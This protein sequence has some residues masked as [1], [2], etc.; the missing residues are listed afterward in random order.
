MKL[1]IASDHAGFRHKERLID[2]LRNS[3]YE[4]EDLGPHEYN[5]DDDYPDYIIPVARGVSE[6]PKDT[7]GIILG[8]SGQGE[9]MS[10]N[11]FRGVRA[12]VFYGGPTSIVSLSREHNNA[13][14]LSIGAR[15]VSETEMIDVVKLWLLTPF[16]NEER[17]VRRLA[18]LEVN[19]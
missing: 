1:L 12:V 18:K 6:N 19:G 8:G 3:N 10:A 11:R 4:Y 9:A 2:F 7:K 14:I 13:N 16:S 17:H 5:E 15:F